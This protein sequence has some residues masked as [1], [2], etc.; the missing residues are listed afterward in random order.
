MI[1][2][3]VAYPNKPGARFSS[4]KVAVTVIDLRRFLHV[5]DV[6]TWLWCSS[7]SRM[8]VATTASPNTPP[9]SATDRLLVSSVAPRQVAELIDDQQFGQHFAGRVRTTPFPTTHG[10]PGNPGR[11][12]LITDWWPLRGQLEAHTSSPQS[13]ALLP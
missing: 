13:C 12:N 6:T 1:K 8:A 4:T 11:F 2:V 3:T 5:E 7:R 9:H 10:R